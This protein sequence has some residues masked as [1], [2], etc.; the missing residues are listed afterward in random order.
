MAQVSLRD[1][2]TWQIFSLGLLLTYGV[3]ILSFDQTPSNIALIIATAL[4]TQW[5]CARTI[6]NT[7]FDPLSPLITA[8][9]LCLLLRT[10]SPVYLVLG[11][12]LRSAAS[13]YCAS[14]ASTFLTPQ[15]SASPY[16]CCSPI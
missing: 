10:S 3:G 16:C 7:R 2:R 15:I 8:F 4:S 14:T 5:L 1:A 13:S 12:V 6:A 9:S 11:A